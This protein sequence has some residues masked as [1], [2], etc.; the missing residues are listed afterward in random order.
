[1][2]VITTNNGQLIQ[3]LDY[4][5]PTAHQVVAFNVNRVDV[6][7]LTTIMFLGF[8]EDKREIKLQINKLIIMKLKSGT[9]LG[10][11]FL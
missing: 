8:W 6:Q 9:T 7:L 1:M 4:L 3:I 5:L 2:I 11:D 10:S